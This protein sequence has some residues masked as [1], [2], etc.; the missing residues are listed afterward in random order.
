[1]KSTVGPMTGGIAIPAL[2][3]NSRDLQRSLTPSRLFYFIVAVGGLALFLL[4]IYWMAITAVKP[5][6]EVLSIPP[7]F[8]PS[9]F[10][11]NGLRDVLTSPT[12]LKSIE[13]SVILTVIPVVGDTVSA[14]FV[15]YAFARLR[16][17]GSGVL[18]ALMLATIMVPFQVTLIPQFLLF[19]WLGWV[20]TFLPLIVPTFFGTAFNV[21][22]LRQF[23]RQIPR[24]LDEAA[25]LDGLGHFGIFFRIILPLSKPA[26]AAVATFSFVYHWNDFLYP[27]V[28]LNSPEKYPIPY[29]INQYA[30]GAYGNV[31]YNHFFSLGLISTIPCLILFFLAQRYFVKGIA[32]AGQLDAM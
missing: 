2:I 25:T 3:R 11:L 17:P 14:A 20:D 9:T 1:M 21:F 5:E 16:A 23:F 28:Y 18:F 30:S 6:S 13:N 32:V 15:A 12:L 29:A 22:L 8:W 4:P 7:S 27:L 26:L 10:D 19:N 31:S 24:E